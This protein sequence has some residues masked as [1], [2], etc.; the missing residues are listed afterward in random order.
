MTS[1]IFI[2]YRRQDS[3][4]DARSICQ[5][6]EKTFGKRKVFIDVDSI[7]PG[8]DFQSVLKN[9]LEKCNIVLVVIGPRWLELLRSSGLT[10][11]ATGQDYVRLEVASALEHKL[12][13]FPVLVDGAT[14]PEAKDLPDDLKPLSFRQAFSIRHDSFP[15][16]M[17]ELEQ[18][19]RRYVSTRG[20]WKVALISG[21]SII[22]LG[23]SLGAIYL[24][25]WPSPLASANTYSKV[26]SFAC[27]G[28]AEYPDSWRAEAALCVTYGCNFGKMSQ[29]ACLALGARKRSKTVIHGKPFTGRA[30]ECWLQ[31][32]CGDLRPHGEFTLFKM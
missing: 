17:W 27:F 18:E 26:G 28:E 30:N 12:P 9:D 16:D 31:D 19:L 6:L 4:S 29:D 11:S 25:I 22:L 32:S 21:L 13:L 15:R 10:D 8:E 20:I 23:I 3:K 24:Y 7:R 14:M 1:G 2:S 5:R